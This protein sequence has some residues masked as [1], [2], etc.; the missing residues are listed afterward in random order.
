VSANDETPGAIPDEAID[1]AIL[2]LCRA[3]GR[4]KTI[5]PSEVARALV[6]DEPGWRALMGR[7]RKRA[8][9]LA[10]TGEIECLQKGKPADALAA[11]GPI[12]LR[13]KG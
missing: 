2:C 11:R 10:G 5:C 6:S 9:A 13:A 3:R 1:R 8:A 12:R 4:A 7:M